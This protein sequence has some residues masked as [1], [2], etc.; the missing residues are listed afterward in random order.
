M[1]KCPLQARW[2]LKRRNCYQRN[3]NVTHAV[4]Y[5]H[6]HL[7]KCVDP[8]NWPANSQYLNP[9]DVSVW[10]ALQQNLCR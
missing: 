5:L 8:E 9:V 6:F 2:C 4:A 3:V 10:A 1:V 7:P